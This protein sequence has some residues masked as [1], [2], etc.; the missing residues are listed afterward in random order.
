MAKEES[1][2]NKHVQLSIESGVAPLELVFYPIVTMDGNEPKGFRSSTIIH[3]I[4]YGDLKEDKYLHIT[5]NRA[6]G[7]ELLKHNIQHAITSLRSFDK[8]KKRCD[9]ITVRCPSQILE[10]ASI[11]DIVKEVLEVNPNVD[12]SRICIEFPED[13][14]EQNVERVQKS[15]LD[16]KVLK[17]KTALQGVGREDFKISKLVSIPV[18]LAI[19]DKTAS[20][21]AGSRNKPQLFNSLLSYIKAMGVDSIAVGNEAEK[22]E[23][24][25]SEA[26]GFM[27]EGTEPITLIEAINMAEESDF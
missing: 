23:M 2:F 5:D 24:H 18:D 22:K 15:V 14:V 10:K 17:V 19:L 27:F 6:V 25:F 4:L 8:A 7:I 26:V 20:E 16:L 12:P 3:S 1:Q 21:W 11:Y 13:L 9:Y